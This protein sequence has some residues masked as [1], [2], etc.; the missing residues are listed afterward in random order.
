[1]GPV[2]GVRLCRELVPPFSRSRMQR[3]QES[4][5]RRVYPA[6][7]PKI[8]HPLRLPFAPPALAELL[9]KVP[10]SYQGSLVT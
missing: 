3:L 5:V 7:W 4:A 8:H 6:G 10:R 1:M 9:S 2:Y